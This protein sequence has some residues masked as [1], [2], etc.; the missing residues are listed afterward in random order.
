MLGLGKAL[1]HF[2]AT[3][4]HDIL[5]TSPE[6][7]G[8]ISLSFKNTSHCDVIVVDRN[9]ETLLV[10]KALPGTD[11]S[12]PGFE[13]KMTRR[14][15]TRASTN[16]IANLT[17][18]MA[19]IIGGMNALHKDTLAI[20]TKNIVEGTGATSI[21]RRFFVPIKD[22]ENDRAIFEQQ[23]GLVLCVAG[24]HLEVVHPESQEYRMR[25]QNNEFLNNQPVG[26]LY[27][28]VDNFRTHK[29]RFVFVGNEVLRIH[30]TADNTRADGLYVTEVESLGGATSKSVTK[31]YEFEEGFK[32]FG[33]FLTKEEALTN[34]NP[35][36]IH[37]LELENLKAKLAHSEQLNRLEASK[38]K[39]IEIVQ[40][41]EQREKDNFIRD[42]ERAESVRQAA[43]T[44]EL[45]R[46]V[47]EQ[48]RITAE[49]A[50][51][52]KRDELRR[53]MAQSAYSTN[54]KTTSETIKFI[55]A[56]IAGVVAICGG[57]VLWRKA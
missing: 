52:A 15:A 11:T 30:Y 17:N 20:L 49:M 57:L 10:E 43:Y 22:I 33:L 35:S 50:E 14:H 1:R 19:S 29:E 51:K 27:E 26:R 47:E 9:N 46:Q 37:Q 21:A 16:A 7:N 32:K 54:L 40:T 6:P 8:Y 34:G 56:L 38:D 4:K 36:H 48:K 24:G 5:D 42:Q 28:I 18:T 2:I 53:E 13:I 23:S 25:N 39:G 41:R 31:H 45:A 55:P 12:V 44:A 3:F